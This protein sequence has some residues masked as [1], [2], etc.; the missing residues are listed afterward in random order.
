VRPATAWALGA[1]LI[2]Y[3]IVRNLPFGSALAP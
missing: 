1:V 3:W 2:L